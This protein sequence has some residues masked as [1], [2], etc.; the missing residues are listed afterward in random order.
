MADVALIWDSTNN[1]TDISVSGGDL[2]GNDDL[3]S[4]VIMS[5]FTF[6]RANDD[7]S[8]PDGTDDRRGWYGDDLADVEGDQIGSRLW[9][10]ERAKITSDTVLRVEE[11]AAEALQWIIDDKVA[12]SVDVAATRNGIDR[13][14]LVV[15]IN[16]FDGTTENLRFDDIWSVTNG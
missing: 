8:I 9:L 13:I 12:T 16:R 4:S 3:A 10:L 2:L 1:A 5:L 6:R 11:Y 7:D 14:D 15:V